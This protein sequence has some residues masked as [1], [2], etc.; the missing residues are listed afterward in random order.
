MREAK[1]RFSTERPGEM[2]TSAWRCFSAGGFPSSFESL[3]EL[4]G[5]R[6]GGAFALGIREGKHV[7]TQPVGHGVELDQKGVGIVD[8]GGGKGVG[9]SELLL[10]RRQSRPASCST[11]SGGS[12]WA[13]ASS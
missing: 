2:A 4:F 11:R 7:G 5:D 13:P 1:P 10:P 12:D 8:S 9:Q 6:D 3:F